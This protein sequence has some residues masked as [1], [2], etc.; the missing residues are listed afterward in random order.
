M[1]LKGHIPYE[2][3]DEMSD[4]IDA[5]VDLL[6]DDE[7]KNVMSRALGEIRIARRFS[8]ALEGM[9]AEAAEAP[10]EGTV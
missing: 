4:E 5:Q 2:F 10:E 7:K 1:F 9:T 6:P 8:E 3:H